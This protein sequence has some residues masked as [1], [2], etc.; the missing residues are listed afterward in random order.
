M[1]ECVSAHG[2]KV[3]FLL[4]TR[5][6]ELSGLARILY[7]LGRQTYT[8]VEVIIVLQPLSEIARTSI[9]THLS[10]ER[11]LRV[12]LIVSEAVGLTKSRNTALARGAGDLL[13]LCDDDCRYPREAA[14]RI[15]KAEE[16]HPEWDILTFK[17]GAD[18]DRRPFKTYG[19]YEMEHRVCTLMNVSSIETV[20]RRR[21][22][23][24]EGPMLFDERYG[25]GT[26]FITGG[27]NI[28]LVDLYRKGYR[29]GFIP[30]PIVTHAGLSS[31]RGAIEP[32]KMAFAEGAMFR[33]IF[34]AWG[35]V[36]A[37]VFFVRRLFPGKRLRFRLQ[38]VKPLTDGYAS[39]PLN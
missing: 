38:H 27:E 17:V 26:P 14:S 28:M 5:G 4:S 35:I 6:R 34:G 2:R 19:S 7:D 32:A 37:S 23:D 18:A 3:S 39:A 20:I 15:V 12:S 9:E 25:L 36:P 22:C 11:L 13:V 31:A 21:V 1:N 30:Q 33:R 24:A 16:A 29:A 10:S 8:N